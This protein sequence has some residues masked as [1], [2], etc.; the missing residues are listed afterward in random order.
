MSF[1]LETVVWA[2]GVA[3]FIQTKSN[4]LNRMNR[5]RHKNQAIRNKNQKLLQY[6]QLGRECFVPSGILA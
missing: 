2:T 5:M 1:V 4:V 6:G 3:S